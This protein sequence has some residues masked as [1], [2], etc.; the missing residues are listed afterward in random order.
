MTVVET[1][2]LILRRLTLDDAEFILGLLNEPSFL[3]YIGDRGA[4]T[5]DDAR[6]YIAAGPLASY[7]RFGFGLLLVVRKE[8][9]IPM[10]MCGLLKRDTLED[11]DVGFALLPQF[12]SKG[13]ASEAASTVMDWGRRVL[14][15]KRIVAITTS[16]NHA[17]ARVLEKLGMAFERM[18]RL[19]PDEEDLRLFATPPEPAT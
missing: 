14:G 5:V 4:R 19:P 1:E 15:L 17:S 10:G 6:K 3:K 8:D 11:V 9:G 16:D 13:Y 18:V 7:A 2:R 12:W